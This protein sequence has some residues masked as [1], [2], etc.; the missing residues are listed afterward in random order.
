MKSQAQPKFSSGKWVTLAI[1]GGGLIL[2]FARP[3]LSKVFAL[4]TDI[5]MVS[6]MGPLWAFMLVCWLTGFLQV[7]RRPAEKWTD[8]WRVI[9]ALVSLVVFAIPQ[10]DFINVFR[11]T[12]RFPHYIDPMRGILLVVTPLVFYAL[13]A[14][15]VVGSWL[16]LNRLVSTW[17]AL[18]LALVI[19]GVVYVPFGLLVNQLMLKYSQP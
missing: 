6:V 5:F 9:F 10:I 7:I 15:V 12:D 14:A 19:F 11:E 13:P 16:G 1:W 8:L 2:L 17:R 4:N 3:W 18:G